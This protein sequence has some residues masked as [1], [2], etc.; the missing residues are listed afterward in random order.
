M[1]LLIQELETELYYVPDFFKK[2]KNIRHL[3]KEVL[4]KFFK[5]VQLKLQR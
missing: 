3:L 1:I 2:E 5:A 4:L